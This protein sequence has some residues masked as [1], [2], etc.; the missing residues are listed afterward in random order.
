VTIFCFGEWFGE[1]GKDEQKYLNQKVEI[2]V[3]KINKT[4]K[5]K[6]KRLTMFVNKSDSKGIPFFAVDVRSVNILTYAPSLHR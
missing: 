5:K 1:F 2:D 4:D 3:T 6:V